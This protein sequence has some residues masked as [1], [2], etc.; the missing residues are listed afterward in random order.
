MHNDKRDMLQ[1]IFIRMC[2]H[3]GLTLEG[4]EP[5][6]NYFIASL[7]AYPEDLICAAYHYILHHPSPQNFPT[8]EDFITF[9]Q[10]EFERRQRMMHDAEACY[11]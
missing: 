9:M 4:S 11:G 8:P 6:R 5:K 10:P 7:L 1:Q 3:Y 2:F